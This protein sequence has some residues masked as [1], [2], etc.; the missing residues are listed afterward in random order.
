MITGIEKIQVAQILIKHA[1]TE[2]ESAIPDL[3]TTEV[4]TGMSHQARAKFAR[5]MILESLNQ[6]GAVKKPP[7]A[8]AGKQRVTTDGAKRQR[9][10]ATA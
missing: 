9:A 7:K 2:I 4:G 3:D 5:A 8:R 10:K 6:L 1:V